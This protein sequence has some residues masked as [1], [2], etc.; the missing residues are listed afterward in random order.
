MWRFCATV[1]WQ[2]SATQILEVSVSNVKCA[3]CSTQIMY[4]ESIQFVLFALQV[5]A[6]CNNFYLAY[7]MLYA[8]WLYSKDVKPSS[9]W[10][11]QKRAYHTYQRRAHTRLMRKQQHAKKEIEP[12]E[13]GSSISHKKMFTATKKTGD[14]AKRR[15]WIKAVE[16][17]YMYRISCIQ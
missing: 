9:V 8:G 11:K 2:K 1:W 17:R 14:F 4:V 7:L 6:F 16:E 3:T 10:V 12:W 13:Y 5:K 15:R